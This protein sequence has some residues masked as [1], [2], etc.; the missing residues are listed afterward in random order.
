MEWDLPKPKSVVAVGDDLSKL[1][2]S[3]LNDR[4]EALKAEIVRTEA[5]ASDKRRHTAAA[6]A[7][8]G[9]TD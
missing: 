1:S 8:F 2:I 4:V 5:A 7:L 9:K 3:E 6:D